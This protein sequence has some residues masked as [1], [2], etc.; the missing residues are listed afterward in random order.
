MAPWQGQCFVVFTHS[1]TSHSTEILKEKEI[2]RSRQRTNL[3]I[4]MQGLQ[5]ASPRN[6]QQSHFELDTAEVRGETMVN[7]PPAMSLTLLQ[8]NKNNSPH[9]KTKTS[10]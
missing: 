10:F 5:P 8:N 7:V 2:K 3:G 6:H 4:G 9:T 1:E